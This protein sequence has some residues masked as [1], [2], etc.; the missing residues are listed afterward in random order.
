MGRSC[1]T[2]DNFLNGNFF[3]VLLLAG[4]L[5]RVPIKGFVG[6]IFPPV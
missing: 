5:I 4:F 3:P 2:V 6:K 1:D